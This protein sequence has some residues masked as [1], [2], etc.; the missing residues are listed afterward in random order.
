MSSDATTTQ[1]ADETAIT[2]Y[3]PGHWYWADLQTS[4]LDGATEF[5]TGL[6]GWETSD[7]TGPHGVY[8]MAKLGGRSVAAMFP[9]AQHLREQGLPPFWFAYVTVADVDAATAKV[10]DLGGTV[11]QGPFPVADA[12][13]MSI[14]EDPSGAHFALWQAVEHPGSQL[15]AVEGTLCWTELHSTDVEVVLPFYEGL[16][17]WTY[18]SMP[19]G[20]GASYHVARTFEGDGGQSCGLMQQFAA[21]TEMGIPSHW[22][23]YFAVDDADAIAARTTELGG[24]VVVAPEDIPGI[25]RFAVL[26]DPQGGTFSVLDPKPPAE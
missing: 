20:D 13:R 8:R 11:V 15:R 17:G 14:I 9:Q 6:F 2:E 26:Q 4:D 19:M 25:G 3:L 5:Y 23:T 1:A 16:L 21:Q 24:S 7:S 10:A 12:G 22:S 18:D